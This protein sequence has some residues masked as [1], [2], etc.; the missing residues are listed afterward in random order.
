MNIGPVLKPDKKN[1][2][3]KKNEDDFMSTNCE[4]MVAFPIYG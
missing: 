3:S 1:K 4:V 2:K